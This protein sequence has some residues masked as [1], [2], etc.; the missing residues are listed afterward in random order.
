MPAFQYKALDQNGKTE[1][2]LLEADSARQIRQQLR[3]KGLLPVAV[4]AVQKA[5]SG[6][7]RFGQKSVGAYDLA[8]ITRQLSVLL[9]SSIPLEQAL[10]AVAKQSEKTHIKALNLAVRSK[11]LEGYS[12][13]NA[14]QDAGNFPPIYTATIAAGE[15]SGHLDL[16]LNQ[17]ADYTENRFA[18]QKKIQGALVYPIILLIMAIAVVV[19][20]MT[21]VVPK[22]VKVFEQSDQALP[23]I[24]QFVLA[25]SYVLTT[26]WWLLLLV[27][28]GGL[29]ILIKFVKTS[30]GRSTFDALVLRLP[31]F[32]K[33]SYNL[34]ASRFAST[35][36]I[37][38]RSGV[39]LVEALAIGG[40]VLGNV[41]IR[42][43]VERATEKVIEGANLSGQLEKSN[44]F[45][46]MM[47]QMI[48]SGEQSG[49]LD[50]MLSRA[51]DM[52]QN[53][54][55]NMISTL[56]ALLEPLMLVLMGV[57]VM[58]IVMA[59]MLPIVNMN[60]LAG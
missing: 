44:Y 51:A 15:R 47:V 9:A 20:L 39:P 52:Q 57:I 58:T 6:K 3:E 43:A 11:V 40:A 34:N 42:Y 26:W 14:L 13:A 30:A 23:G 41:H 37:L 7:K 36:S 5:N 29:V 19:G 24:T 55:T 38:V 10:N 16:I 25:V 12:L 35:L 18:M 22:I 17:L 21:L 2:G 59:V 54:A 27:I 53:E 4:N 49:E 46:P 1:Q 32:A 50:N 48:K 56:L 28:V 33:L 31:I 8:L 60:D 45:P